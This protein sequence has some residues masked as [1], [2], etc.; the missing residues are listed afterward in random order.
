MNL[1]TI[2][3]MIGCLAVGLIAGMIIELMIDAQTV[4]DLQSHNRKLQLENAQLR[5][6]VKHEVIE[7][8]DNRSDS[9]YVMPHYEDVVDFTF[10]NT[11][12]I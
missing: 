5:Q 10:P 4:R 2:I 3:Y 12:G 1:L 11:E 8:F 7:I 9:D 6:E